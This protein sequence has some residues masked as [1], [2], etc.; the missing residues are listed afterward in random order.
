M[1]TLM[2]SEPAPNLSVATTGGGRWTLSDQK[3]EGFTM[4]VFYRG[5]HCPICKSYLSELNGR[6]AEFEEAGV[7]VVAVSMDDEARAKESVATWELDR[8]NV[9]YGLGEADARGWGLYLSQAIKDGEPQLF[10]EP[11][12]FLIDPEGKLYLI[13]VSSMPFA[14][15]QL[16]GLAGKLAF[17]RDKSYPARGIAA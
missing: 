4:V 8:L 14:R 13:N 1:T 7:E 10:S 3:P 9:G 17:A 5:R 2:P 15:P 11:G 16:E 6:L 12:L